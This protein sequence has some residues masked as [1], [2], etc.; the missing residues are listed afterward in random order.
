MSNC[1]CH[2]I[3]VHRNY[4]AFLLLIFA[5]AANILQHYVQNSCTDFHAH[6]TIYMWK[7]VKNYMYAPTAI[8]TK[9]IV[10]E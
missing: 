1:I 3:D 8:F 6:P 4:A 9:F 2:L 7:K 5:N 10:N